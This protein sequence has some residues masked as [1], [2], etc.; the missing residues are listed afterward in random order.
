MDVKEAECEIV[1][2]IQQVIKGSN[3]VINLRV[4]QKQIISWPAEE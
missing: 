3:K 1:D 2:W 4:P